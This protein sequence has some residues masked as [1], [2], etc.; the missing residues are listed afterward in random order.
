VERSVRELSVGVAE[1]TKGGSVVVS[2]AQRGDLRAP[3]GRAKPLIGIVN[4][5]LKFYW[6]LII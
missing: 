1:T 5:A 2:A 3:T 4:M 6:R